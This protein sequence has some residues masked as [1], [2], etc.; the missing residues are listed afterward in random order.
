MRVTC[1]DWRMSRRL[2]NA[3]AK[4]HVRAEFCLFGQFFQLSHSL[5]LSVSLGMHNCGICCLS[6]T[7]LVASLCTSRR[8]YYCHHR[9]D[10]HHHH[11]HRYITFPPTLSLSLYLLFSL[12]LY[13][14]F[15]L[16]IPLFSLLATRQ[17]ACRSTHSCRHA[18]RTPT[19]TRH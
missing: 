11:H 9:H 1:I 16:S 4:S 12:S 3:W 13:S 2:C 19:H 6:L 10:H 15:S 5:H 17:T 18:M 8:V 14:H 7:L